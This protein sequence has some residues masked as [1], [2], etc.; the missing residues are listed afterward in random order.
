VCAFIRKYNTKEEKNCKDVT[1]QCVRVRTRQKKRKRKKK[2]FLFVG[3]LV[4]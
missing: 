1:A 4:F 3:W 2:N